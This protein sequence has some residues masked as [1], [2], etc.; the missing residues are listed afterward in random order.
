MANHANGEHSL[1]PTWWARAL[2]AS[3]VVATD[4]AGLDLLSVRGRHRWP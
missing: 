4:F 2:E 1:F 3:G